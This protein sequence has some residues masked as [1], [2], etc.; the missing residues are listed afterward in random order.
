MAPGGPGQLG[1]EVAKVDIWS[2]L[3][4][5][6]HVFCT[7]AVIYRWQIMAVPPLGV[8][9]RLLKATFFCLETWFTT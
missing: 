8:R 7:S 3:P 6:S 4:G 5:G 9:Q 2:P 1:S